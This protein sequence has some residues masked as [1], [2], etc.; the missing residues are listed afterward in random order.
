MLYNLLGIFLF[1]PISYQN[2][3]FPKLPAQV[4][5][6]VE[7]ECFRSNTLFMCPV[8]EHINELSHLHLIFSFY[9]NLVFFFIQIN[10]HMASLEIKAVS[11]FL[12]RYIHSVVERLSIHFADNIERWHRMIL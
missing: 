9:I 2:L 5:L 11:D 4:T 7:I 3:F 10:D 1:E 8:Y 6:L 12:G